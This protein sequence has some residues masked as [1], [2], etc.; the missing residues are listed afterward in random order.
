MPA[1]A[2]SLLDGDGEHQARR[3]GCAVRTQRSDIGGPASAHRQSSTRAEGT[4]PGDIQQ[5]K[6]QRDRL[7]ARLVWGLEGSG[8][9]ALSVHSAYP[10]M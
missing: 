1:A 10:Q 9:T 7:A 4:E 2:L 5:W 6:Q 3:R 8:H